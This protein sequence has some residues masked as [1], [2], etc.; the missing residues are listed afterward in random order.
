M[1]R[2][3]LAIELKSVIRHANEGIHIWSKDL[4]ALKCEDHSPILTSNESAE[5][6]T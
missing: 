6:N 3:E 5:N 1:N 4:N 2:S